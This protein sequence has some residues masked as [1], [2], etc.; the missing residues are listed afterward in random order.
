MWA[1]A[2]A[3]DQTEAARDPGVMST[4]YTGLYMN[5]I[6]LISGGALPVFLQ[7]SLQPND[8]IS[9]IKDSVVQS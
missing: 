8:P 7:T 1:A 2:V 6:T 4:W 5:Y 9:K 3:R